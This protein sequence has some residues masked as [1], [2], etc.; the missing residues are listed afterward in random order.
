[1]SNKKTI[2][3]PLV[4]ETYVNQVNPLLKIFAALKYLIFGTSLDEV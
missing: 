2:Y 3:V 1:M 4:A